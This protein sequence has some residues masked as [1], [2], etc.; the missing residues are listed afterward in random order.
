[1]S[2]YNASRNTR[3]N[4][5]MCK[6]NGINY[7]LFISR[8]RHAVTCT[9]QSDRPLHLDSRVM[10]KQRNM[11]TECDT[12]RRAACFEH[13]ARELRMYLGADFTLGPHHIVSG[14]SRIPLA[15]SAS[16]RYS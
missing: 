11:Q 14:A 7:G 2:R 9:H 8:C 16:T 13:A 6:A 10:L 12:T 15:M 1:M 5:R 4:K 3:V